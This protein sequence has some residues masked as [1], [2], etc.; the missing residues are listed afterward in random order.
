MAV[1]SVPIITSYFAWLGNLS[2]KDLGKVINY[3]PAWSL[4][5]KWKYIGLQ[6]DIT[7]DT[8]NEIEQTKHGITNDCFTE[9]VSLWLRNSTT[10]TWNELEKALTAPSVIGKYYYIYEYVSVQV[11]VHAWERGDFY[12]PIIIE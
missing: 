10:A 6:L 7:E 3:E 12:H 11:C 2:S 4:R 1:Y 9:V 8:L 5:H